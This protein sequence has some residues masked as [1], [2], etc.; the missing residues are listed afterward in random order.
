M[1]AGEGNMECESRSVYWAGDPKCGKLPSYGRFGRAF[2]VPDPRG[3]VVRCQEVPAGEAL[4]PLTSELSCLGE[5]RIVNTPAP[6]TDQVRSDLRVMPA[7]EFRLS[8]AY[9]AAGSE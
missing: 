1:W 2:I 4:G 6:S 3:G 9:G 5:S 8:L 7:G